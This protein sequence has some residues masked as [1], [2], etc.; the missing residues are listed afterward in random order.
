[1]AEAENGWWR[2]EVEMADVIWCAAHLHLIVEP[3]AWK[4]PEEDEIEDEETNLVS[5]ERLKVN[6][7]DSTGQNTAVDLDVAKVYAKPPPSQ[8]PPPKKVSDPSSKQP[9]SSVRAPKLF[10][11]PD[12]REICRKAWPLAKRVPGRIKSELDINA[13]VLQTAEAGGLPMPVLKAPL[14]R[15]F[16]L[17]LMVDRSPSMEF[18]G[19]LAADAVTL[20]RWLG[21]FRDVR[22]WELETGRSDFP[23]LL[24]GHGHIVRPWGSAISP[25]DNRLFVVLTDTVGKAWQSGEAFEFLGNLGASHPVHLLHL[26]PRS[27][28]KRTALETTFLRPLN[29]PTA[30]STN[31]NLKVEGRLR[32]TKRRRKLFCFPIFNLSAD[33]EHMDIWASH[34]AGSGGNAIQ[35]VLFERRPVPPRAVVSGETMK[36]PERLL[37]YFWSEASQEAKDLAGILAALPLILPVMHLARETFLPKSRYWHLAEVFFS[38]LLQRS[39]LGPPNASISATWFDF[40]DGVRERLLAESSVRQTTNVWRTLGY[41]LERGHSSL[42]SFAAFI[43]NPQGSVQEIV[44]DADFYFAEVRGAVLMTWGGE[45]ASLGR[46]LVERA[47]SRKRDLRREGKTPIEVGGDVEDVAK[48]PEL[49]ERSFETAQLIWV[50]GKFEFQIF[51]AHAQEDKPRVRELYLQLQEAGY[52]PWLDEVDLMPGQSWK[53]EIPKEIAR[54]NLFLA[55]LSQQSIAKQGYVQREFRLA[56]DRYA[57]G[58]AGESSF[59]PLK[60]DDCDIPDLSQ[61]ETGIALRDFQSLDY[62]QPDGFDKLLQ[63]I[64]RRRLQQP[65]EEESKFPP[66]LQVQQV[67]VVTIELESFAKGDWEVY[68]F[69]TATISRESGSWVVKRNRRVSQ[70]RLLRVRLSD[71]VVLE[72]V[73]IPGGTF[74]MGS[75][76]NELKRERWEGPQHEVVVP[77]F[78]IGRYPVTQAQWQF[79]AGLPQVR[80]ELKPNPSRFQ[81]SDRP[82][83]NVS[84][85]EAV[86]FC[87]RLSA[88]TGQEYRLPSEAEWEYA[89]RA[90]TKTPF[91]YG[92]TL[93]T[94]LAN[95]RR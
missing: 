69:E 59:I 33:R 84:W 34:L 60:L 24:C 58:P 25:G 48:F 87:D 81:G 71:D 17:H 12:K 89:C 11:F 91:C 68:E 16:E 35:G 95:Y 14:K 10:S 64:E 63:A 45:V 73:A 54:S 6:E 67:V 8:A 70:G 62:W 32:A 53:E 7:T 79:V 46:E 56:L 23:K 27:L 85:Y 55:C 77:S 3:D 75:L 65:D 1:M 4:K 66:P 80:V 30:G 61:E 78:E 26:L 5:D 83:E 57:E 93:S 40:Q 22:V 44:S 74:R 41:W 13:T 47:Q 36:D 42:S 29:A 2:D 19:E 50:P 20:F 38:G 18:W 9:A 88:L 43:P 52:R 15:R 94:E 92:E 82:V 49:Q 86:E 37:D 51:L 28:W 90:G 31:K 39:V 76:E 72:M 21:V